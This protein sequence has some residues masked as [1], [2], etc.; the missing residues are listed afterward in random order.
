MEWLWPAIVSA[1]GP[2]RIYWW[3]G[4]T[5]NINVLPTCLPKASHKV[6]L[7]FFVPEA[8]QPWIANSLKILC[9]G[10][11]REGCW[12]TEKGISWV[13]CGKCQTAWCNFSTSI[14]IWKKTSLMSR[15]WN[16]NHFSLLV[17]FKCN[18][19]KMEL[20]F[21]LSS[22]LQLGNRKNKKSFCDVHKC[23]WKDLEEL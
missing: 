6:Y 22:V 20:N 14:S 7:N 23:D 1:D 18:L 11:S 10:W 19:S 4:S 21:F 3:P 17:D 13:F 16:G 15:G 5:L 2:S 9:N 12:Q 8:G